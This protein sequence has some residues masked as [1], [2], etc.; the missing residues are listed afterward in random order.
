MRLVSLL[1]IGSLGPVLLQHT[2]QKR[3]LLKHIIDSDNLPLFSNTLNPSHVAA[4]GWTTDAKVEEDGFDPTHCVDIA[5]QLV[6]PVLKRISFDSSSDSSCD[7]S[8]INY[9]S[10]LLKDLCPLSNCHRSPV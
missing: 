8:L 2:G 7:Q 3:N 5:K 4:R 9:A 1:Q 10:N 6:S